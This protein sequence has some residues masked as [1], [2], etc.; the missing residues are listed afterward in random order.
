MTISEKVMDTKCVNFNVVI[1]NKV[2]TSRGGK[3]PFS[4][5]IEVIMDD[6]RMGIQNL[7]RKFDFVQGGE[8]LSDEKKREQRWRCWIE[9]HGEKC[10]MKKR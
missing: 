5:I 2:G 3:V 4:T 8:R 1:K 10:Q 9:S 6:T 7:K